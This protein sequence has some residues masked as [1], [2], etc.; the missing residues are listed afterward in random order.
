MASLVSAPL[1]IYLSIPV[2]CWLMVAQFPMFS[3]KFKKLS[4]AGNEIRIIF[5]VVAVLM[6][7][8]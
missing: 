2:L 1:F 3:L 6:G 7:V 8:C 5:A 4:W